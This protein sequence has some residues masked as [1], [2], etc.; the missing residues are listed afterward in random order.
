MVHL[1]TMPTE[2]CQLRLWPNQKTAWA[3]QKN[4]QPA[5]GTEK[6]PLDYFY[7]VQ[8]VQTTPLHDWLYLALMADQLDKSWAFQ[9]R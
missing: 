5:I 7:I 4:R 3:Q 8:R 2:L 9:D 1:K 6:T